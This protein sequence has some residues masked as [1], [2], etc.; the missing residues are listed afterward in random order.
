MKP[1]DRSAASEAGVTQ[2]IAG[3]NETTLPANQPLTGP[4]LDAGEAATEAWFQ[5]PA[6]G[7][8]LSGKIFGDYELLERLGRGG[9]GVVYKARQRR[10]NRIVALKMIRSGEL[11]GEDEVARFY[12]EAEAAAQLDHPNIV[13]VFEVGQHE[14]EHFF[15]MGYV[16]GPTLAQ[17]IA[18]GPLLPR[19]AAE[20]LREICEGV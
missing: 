20:L 7:V 12:T 19:E 8:E 3:G 6:R 11:A 1:Q 2:S 17:R 14:G 18:A 16:D 9:M 10:L 13:P 15:S 4:L 5:R